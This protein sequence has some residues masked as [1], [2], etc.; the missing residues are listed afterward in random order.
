MM[1]QGLAV[2][3]PGLIGYGLLAHLSRALYAA[4]RG[5]GAATAV[6]AGWLTVLV[7][8]L[9]LVTLLPGQDA[10]VALGLGNGLG[11]SVAGAA[12]LVA[13]RRAAG[14]DALAGV[15]R[16]AAVAAV[17]AAVATPVG[18][19][20]AALAGATGPFQAAV[21]GAATALA[22]IALFTV[23]AMAV[24]KRLLPG[25]ECGKWLRATVDNRRR[26]P[27]R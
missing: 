16:A 23:V 11:M 27:G 18:L 14:R 8:D 25:T 4:G 7:A 22:T 1:G 17:A 26:R 12:L 13:V 21:I 19:S 2:F 15:G 6:C 5:R 3:A 24:A 9:A 20:A 10:V